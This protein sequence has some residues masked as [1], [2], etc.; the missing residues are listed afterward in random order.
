MVF[1]RLVSSRRILMILCRWSFYIQDQSLTGLFLHYVILTPSIWLEALAM[2]RSSLAWF[3]TLLYVVDTIRIKIMV[4][5]VTTRPRVF[6]L[7]RWLNNWSS[8]SRNCVCYAEYQWPKIPMPFWRKEWQ[9]L[10]S[11][12]YYGP[13]VG[14]SFQIIWTNNLSGQYR[15]GRGFYQT[16]INLRS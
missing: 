13:N 5:S 14:N 9:V 12:D 4:I 3:V 6:K 7:N 15:N 2:R 1:W 16:A 10:Y 8:V 11:Q